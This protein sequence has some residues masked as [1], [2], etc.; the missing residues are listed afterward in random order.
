MDTEI[1]VDLLCIGSGDGAL[2]AAVSAAKAK[3]SVQFAMQ[4]LTGLNPRVTAAHGQRPWSAAL[5][6]RFGVEISDCETISYL[7]ALTADLGTEAAAAAPRRL[8]ANGFQR[9]EPQPRSTA[10]TFVPTFFGSTLRT[11]ARDCLQSTDSVVS[12]QVTM[13]GMADARSDTGKAVEIAEIGALPSDGIAE[14]ALRNWLLGRAREYGAEISTDS[15]LHRLLFEEDQVVGAVVLEPAGRRVVRTR[16][17]VVLG[18]GAPPDTATPVHPGLLPGGT[19][20]YLVSRYASRF[21]RMELVPAQD[22]HHLHHPPPTD[23]QTGTTP[24]SLKR[25]W[26]AR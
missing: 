23:R 3:L 22:V 21:G 9:S 2:A 19:R 11:W 8:V 15:M 10:G 18:T 26:A 14:S 6:E 12:T 20:V 25:A 17:G 4:P 24:D 13:P 5:E 7:D 1:E 16:Y